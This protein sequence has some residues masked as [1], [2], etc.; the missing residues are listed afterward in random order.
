MKNINIAAIIS[1]IEELPIGYISKKYINGKIRYYRQWNENGKIRSQYIK[2]SELETIQSQIAKR[3][4]LQSVLKEAGATYNAAP[5]RKPVLS[6]QEYTTNIVTGNALKA[7]ATAVAKF[8]RRNCF[9]DLQKYLSTPTIDKVCI[10]YGL[11]RTGKTTLLKQAILKLNAKDFA[12]AAYI[13]ISDGD[14]IAKLNKDLKQ[15]YANDF[16]FIFIDEVTLLSDFIES[17]SLF[18]DIFAAEGMKIILSGTD[19]LGFWFASHGELYDRSIMI[20]TTFIPYAE[21]SKLLGNKGI[22]EYIRYGGTL[23]AGDTDFGNLEESTFQSNESTRRYIDSAI[24]QNIQHSLKYC[25][26][27]GHFRHLQ[28]LYLKG[29]LTGAINRII[30]DMNHLFLVDILTRNFKSNDLRLAARNLRKEKDKNKRSSILDSISS[31]PIEKK[32]MDILKIKNETQQSIKITDVHVSEIQEY[33]FALDFIARINIETSS[34]KSNPIERTIFTQPGM[35]FCQAQA[36]IY[37]LTQNKEFNSF[38]E[39]EKNVVIERIL[40]DVRGRML[41]DI[42]LYETSITVGH[43]KRVFKLQF[44]EGEFDMVI[45]DTSKDQC[46]LFEIKHSEIAVENQ[47]RHLADEKKLSIA[48]HRFGKITRRCVLYRGKTFKALNGIDYQNV[49]EFLSLLL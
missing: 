36:L 24:C 1:K 43:N 40:D 27:G 7:M 10:I 22:D 15:L 13:K 37:S 35:R 6:N 29:E 49:E 28:S 2:D 39:R 32:L 25:E 18:S 30:E 3:K 5:T 41:E 45:Y 47:S 14:D 26:D 16:R 4:E 19:S 8:K 34:V 31:A 46:E 33:L 17:A 23:R 44:D 21:Y 38:R 42:V 12:K 9:N 20:H 11:R 48:T